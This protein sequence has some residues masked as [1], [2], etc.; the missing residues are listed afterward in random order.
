MVYIRF[1][2]SQ[3]IMKCDLD[4]NGNVVTLSF[5]ENVVVDTS[6]F[7][8]YLDKKGEL[9]I[10]G[11]EYTGFTTVYRNDSETEK[12]NGYQLSNDGS[13][14]VEKEPEIDLEP[15]P[16]PEEI[17]ENERQNKINSIISQIQS[18]KNQLAQTDYIF[19][20][21]YEASTVGEV[22][23]DYNLQDIHLQRQ[24]LRNEIN[25][26]ENELLEMED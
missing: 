7:M 23:E 16:T 1:L 17:K 22:L 3:N 13:V 14:Y 25:T 2:D 10:G 26:L 4:I 18:L 12:Y 11:K 20:K 5:P 8:V 24:N 6:G 19:I 15:T 21:S 9:D